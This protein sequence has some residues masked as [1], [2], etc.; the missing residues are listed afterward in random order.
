MLPPPPSAQSGEGDRPLH[1]SHSGE[2][3]LLGYA[4]DFFGIWER[5][6]LERPVRRFPRTD[7]G[8]REAWA[9]YAAMEPSPTAV[10]LST[11]PLAPAPRA[12]TPPRARVNGA[13]WLL[14]ILLG[15]V[16]GLIAYFVNREADPATARAMLV[17]GIVL[18]L[19][20]V[21]LLASLPTTR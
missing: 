14:P 20:G 3:Y 21:L 10:G 8:W 19:F 18:S 5:T 17:V 2:R 12:P 7:E 13:W 16:G 11:V 6:D 4:R 15:W 9:A 1:L